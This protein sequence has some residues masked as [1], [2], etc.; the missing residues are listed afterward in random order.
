M[1][2]KQRSL[3]GL[4]IGSHC[5]KAVELTQFGNE[6]VLTAYGQNEIVSEGGRADAIIDLIQGR[7]F[8]TRRTCT[9]VSGKSAIT[10]DGT[11]NAPASGSASGATLCTARDSR[12]VKG[13]TGPKGSTSSKGLVVPRVPGSTVMVRGSTVAANCCG[14]IC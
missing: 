1:F 4:D 5:V 12:P 13:S 3:V 14:R 11:V 2:K 10:S 6:T 8:R 9:A 7:A